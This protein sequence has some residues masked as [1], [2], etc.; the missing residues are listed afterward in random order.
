[1]RKAAKQYIIVYKVKFLFCFAEKFSEHV[2]D[3]RRTDYQIKNNLEQ[4]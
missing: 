2:E 4:D 1:M 3:F